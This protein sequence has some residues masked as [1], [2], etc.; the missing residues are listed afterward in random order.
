MLAVRYNLQ[1]ALVCVVPS[2]AGAGGLQAGGRQG[3]REGEGGG[4]RGGGK[5]GGVLSAAGAPQLKQG[6][7]PDG[8]GLLGSLMASMSLS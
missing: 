1:Q 4:R 8:M 5:G 3:E 6:S 7:I 2:A